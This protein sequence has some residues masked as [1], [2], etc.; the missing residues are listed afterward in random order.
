MAKKDIFEFLS[1]AIKYYEKYQNKF[2]K[3]NPSEFLQLNNNQRKI[4]EQ[5]LKRLE[6]TYPT[7]HPNYIGQMIKPPTELAILSYFAAMFY[8]SNNHALDGGPETSYLEKEIVDELASMIGY[9]KY[10]G[11]LTSGGTMANLEGLWVAKQL[12]PNKLFAICENAHYTHARLSNVL[13]FKYKLIKMN[14]KGKMDLNS[15]ESLLIKKKIGTVLMTLGTTGFGALDDLP[16]I[17]MLKEKFGFRLHV[18]A[19]YGGFFKILANNKSNL[20]NSKIFE[21]THLSDSFVVDPHKHGLQPY[22]CGSILFNDP[23]VG[24]LYKHDSPYTYFTSK[25]LHLGE[26]TL[27]CSRPGASAAA[28][29]ATIK[30]FP[31]SGENELHKILTQTREAAL[32]FYDLIKSSDYFYPV[33]EPELDIVNFFPIEKSTNKI[34]EKSEKLFEYLMRNRKNPIYLS[35]YR[36]DS[37]WFVKKFKHIKM[38]SKEVIVL[39]SVLMKPEHKDYIKNIFDEIVRVYTKIK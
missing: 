2:P 34:S 32:I 7:F 14:D 17:L 31:L 3:F 12:N 18:D 24:K 39:R 22:G 15:L 1:L 8:N 23:K 21:L 30:A 16:E 26:I 25:E 27:E 4:F 10:L 37:K 11:H 19:A 5:L 13:D 20:I 9:K 33:L 28:L 38:N 29:W 6:N 36:I 35:K